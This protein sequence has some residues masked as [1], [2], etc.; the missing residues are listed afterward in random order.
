MID[1]EIIN[2]LLDELSVRLR[3][4]REATLLTALQLLDKRS[5]QSPESPMPDAERI[6]AT[7]YAVYDEYGP[8][9]MD[10]LLDRAFADLGEE[11][12]ILNAQSAKIFFGKV[13]DAAGFD[14]KQV[15]RRNGERPLVWEPKTGEDDV[16]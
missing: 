12:I 7:A 11:N 6:I 4:S 14:R 15:R 16:Q 5:L 2:T 8:F 9:T 13:I 3:T 10:E 1:R